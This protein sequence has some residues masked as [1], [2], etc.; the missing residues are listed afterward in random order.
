MEITAK[1]KYRNADKSKDN[2]NH[3][4]IC[5]NPSNKIRIKK[6][7]LREIKYDFLFQEKIKLDEIYNKFYDNDFLN[8]S[9][10]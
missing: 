5:N 10:T 7:P 8:C 4:R 1:R 2:I 3:K 9:W 6:I